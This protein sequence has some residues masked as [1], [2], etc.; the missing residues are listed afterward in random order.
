VSGRAREGAC[1]TGGVVWRLIL[2]MEKFRGWYVES[3]SFEMLIKGG[4]Y[5]L[6]MVEKGKKKQG[7]I[8]IH[9]DEIHW[10]VGAVEVAL[11]V[12]T[13]E[14]FWDTS[15]AGFP[16]VLVQRRANRHG[17]FIF[18]E[19]YE[20]RNRR[21]SVL[22]PEGRHG[23]GWCRLVSE[24][25]IARSALWKGREFKVRKASRV[26]P[27]R[28]FAEVVGQPQ[29]S[30]VA[31][32]VMQAA[33]ATEK[34]GSCAQ[35]RPKI[36][37][38]KTEEQLEAPKAAGETGG[39]TGV[40]PERIQGQ[41]TVTT[42]R[43]N[44]NLKNLQ[45][46]MKSGLSAPNVVRES[47]NGHAPVQGDLDLQDI[48]NH[49]TGI[50]G[51]LMLGLKRV[52]EV[53]QMLERHMGQVGN[54]WLM[55]PGGN[56]NRHKEKMGN[57]RRNEE[58]GWTKPKKKNFRR[59]SAQPGILGPK[60]SK[61]LSQLS[62]GPAHYRAITRGPTQKQRQVGESPP[63]E[64]VRR[65]GDNGMPTAGNT[66]GE[67]LANA[68]ASFPASVEVYLETERAGDFIGDLG[69]EEKEPS[70]GLGSIPEAADDLGSPSSTPE[71]GSKVAESWRSMFSTVPETDEVLGHAIPSPVKSSNRLLE[72]T[73]CA[74]EGEN[75]IVTPVKQLKQVR[76]FQ[77]RESPSSKSTKSWVAERV[78]WNGGY[79]EDHN[80]S[81]ISEKQSINASSVLG[82]QEEQ[83][84]LGGMGIQENEIPGVE[85]FNP[86][87]VGETGTEEQ[88]DQGMGSDSPVSRDMNMVWKVKGTAGLSWD[89]QVGKLKQVF[90]QIVASKYEEGSSSSL[91][92][93]VDGFKGV[94]ADD[95]PYEA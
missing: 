2:R 47:E 72:F 38:A 36:D 16:R 54:T 63:T 14:V 50:R 46:P 35:T 1:G 51:Q 89:G 56:N 9:R 85:G 30:E 67:H 95:I 87:L 7:T 42:A 41:A 69:R 81:M 66:A 52:D 58:M 11:D 17:S 78:S 64:V 68:G 6:R 71:R 88:L 92:E 61:K 25:K 13:S 43:G 22:I 21:G 70:Q 93:E 76:V 33:V 45:D 12:E 5:G 55:G 91:G 27:G 34:D 10:L 24:L 75:H 65:T 48:S 86:Q 60:P 8:F 83:G 90:G 94:R 31:G 29:S 15:S 74:G 49:L 18:I 84:I 37:P 77:R 28:S 19:E 4:N 62:N 53:F 44:G 80:S 32:K 82:N 73:E 26:T 3:K 40:A 57:K 39:N 20:G 59:V 79:G 23:Q